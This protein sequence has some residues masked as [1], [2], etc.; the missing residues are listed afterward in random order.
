[1]S[2]VRN[3]VFYIKGDLPSA[4]WLVRIK[5]GNAGLYLTN[6]YVLDV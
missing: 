1:M 6:L 2:I 4:L 5:R 3:L